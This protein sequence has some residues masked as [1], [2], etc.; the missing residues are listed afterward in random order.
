MTVC[1]CYVIDIQ[2]DFVVL[3]SISRYELKNKK[4][5]LQMHFT[6]VIRVISV[7]VDPPHRPSQENYAYTDE[8]N[9]I[10]YLS[11]QNKHCSLF[12]YV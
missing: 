6:K 7:I 9:P 5:R 12:G 2:F 8:R 3:P 10:Q 11:N 4:K 1:V